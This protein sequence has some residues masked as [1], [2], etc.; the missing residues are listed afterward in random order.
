MSTKL[1]E[2]IESKGVSKNNLIR[3]IGVDRSTFYQLINGNRVPTE[4]QFCAILR[5]MKLNEEEKIQLIEEFEFRRYWRSQDEPMLKVVRQFLRFLN[6]DQI[7]SLPECMDWEAEN[8]E[9][10][11]HEKEP[12]PQEILEFLKGESVAEGQRKNIKV[13][14]SEEMLNQY[15]WFDLVPYLQESQGLSIS[16]LLI[17]RFH[18]EYNVVQK[19]RNVEMY[20]GIVEQSPVKIDVYR[21]RSLSEQMLFDPYPLWMIGETS[22][23]RI[24]EDL[25]EYNSDCAPSVITRYTRV[26]NRRMSLAYGILKN[27]AI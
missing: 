4:D 23:L 9:D 13:F 8:S 26:F 10:S 5:Q 18:G 6:R 25:K 16:V 21:E 24:S 20:F 12:V 1:S 19:I 7:T 14:L 2:M 11:A 15:D 17:P 22:M 27:T 3:A